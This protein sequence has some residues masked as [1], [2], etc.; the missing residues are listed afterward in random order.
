LGVKAV[1]TF[2]ELPLPPSNSSLT[3]RLSSAERLVEPFSAKKLA[4]V[5]LTSPGDGRSS[6]CFGGEAG[7]AA[8][9]LWIERISPKVCE[10]RRDPREG[11]GA[12]ARITAGQLKALPLILPT[13]TSSSPPL[14]LL[15][16]SKLPCNL[17]ISLFV[18]RD[19]LHDWLVIAALVVD[20]SIFFCMTAI[21]V[22]GS[23]PD[24]ARDHSA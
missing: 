4:R 17:L 20:F 23:S 11:A 18:V 10:V 5:E 15:S 19:D 3:R 6:S 16:S 7:T 14:A 22:L 2:V 24:Q 12:L 13:Y 8:T 9:S 1:G 21:F